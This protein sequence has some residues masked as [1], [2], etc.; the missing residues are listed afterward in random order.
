[1]N[2]D[3]VKGNLLEYICRFSDCVEKILN[4]SKT[5]IIVEKEQNIRL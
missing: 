3:S 2:I 5:K 1:M 4:F